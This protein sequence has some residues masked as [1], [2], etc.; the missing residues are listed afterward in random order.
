MGQHACDCG[1]TRGSHHASRT[2]IGQQ[3]PAFPEAC[4]GSTASQMSAAS[5]KQCVSQHKKQSFRFSE[6]L[7]SFS[8]LLKVLSAAHVSPHILCTKSHSQSFSNLPF[9]NLLKV[10][11]IKCACR[12]VC[13]V[14]LN[15]GCCSSSM[16]HEVFHG[17]KFPNPKQP[18]VRR[19]L[20]IQSITQT[21]NLS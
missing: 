2:W 18:N 3:E 9:S 13:D 19:L 4:N 8:N 15:C 17:Q 12:I 11:H 14:H 16:W 5:A 7:K 1:Q 10:F 20:R 21:T 6:W